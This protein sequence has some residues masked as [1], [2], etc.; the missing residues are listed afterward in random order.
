M[1]IADMA[2][3]K[4]RLDR[5]AALQVENCDHSIDRVTKFWCHDQQARALKYFARLPKDPP[6]MAH[7]LSGFKQGAE[8]MIREWEDWPRWPPRASI[9][10][11]QQRRLG[12]DLL[13][14]SLVVRPGNSKLLPPAGDTAG[15]AALAAREIARLQEELVTWLDEQDEYSREE[16]LV[17]LAPEPDPTTKRL[18]RYEAIF[19]RAYKK[20]ETEFTRVRKEGD[21]KSNGTV[22][23]PRAWDVDPLIQRIKLIERP[24]ALTAEIEAMI[25]PVQ[26]IADGPG[27]ANDPATGG[28]SPDLQ[29]VVSPAPAAAADRVA[30]NETENSPAPCRHSAGE[31]G[32]PASGCRPAGA[33]PSDADR[34]PGSP[35]PPRA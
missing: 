22:T 23:S 31:S 11:K 16:A 18:D 26:R 34:A 7:A 9:G 4:A 13:G 28:V 32:Y 35:E 3:A 29:P 14:V 10:M 2:L 5:V 30:E 19:K 17:G 24:P 20:A 8:L 25:G 6:R 33:D 12:M 27:D 21:A 1:L 15:L